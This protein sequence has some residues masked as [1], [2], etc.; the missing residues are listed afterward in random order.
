MKLHATLLVLKI[1]IL[2]YIPKAMFCW[3]LKYIYVDILTIECV[4][5]QFTIVLLLVL[6]DLQLKVKFSFSVRVM[7]F[8]CDCGFSPY[9]IMIIS[10]FFK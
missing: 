9:A 8:V 3:C 6:F 1:L 10:L 5:I 7:V 4:T 2:W